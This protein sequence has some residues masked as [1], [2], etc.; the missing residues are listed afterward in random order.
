MLLCFFPLARPTVFKVGTGLVD[1]PPAIL[2]HPDFVW[3]GKMKTLL[4]GFCGL[5]LFFVCYFFPLAGCM[6][7]QVK[8][9]DASPK[10]Q[11]FWG[12]GAVL[13]P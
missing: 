10:T 9:F 2:I 1:L 6:R 12:Q 5:F 4:H 8:G 11:V 7:V 13:K 3:G